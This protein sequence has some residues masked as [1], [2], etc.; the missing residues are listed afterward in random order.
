MRGGNLRVSQTIRPHGGDEELRTV[1]V[2]TRIRHGKQSGSVVAHNE[3]LVGELASVDGLA[4]VAIEVLSLTRL[5]NAH[6]NISSLEHES[7]NHSVEDGVLVAKIHTLSSL[8]LLSSAEA[9]EV[10]G[11]LGNDISTQL[12]ITTEM[13]SHLEHNTAH[14]LSIGREV[15]VHQRVLRARGKSTENTRRHS[16]RRRSKLG[17]SKH[18]CSE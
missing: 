13:Q 12:Q 5:T 14:V 6:S 17:E 8:S 11:S 1:R 9:T 4:S 2:G 7:G 10:L 3:A 16:G 15:H 18:C